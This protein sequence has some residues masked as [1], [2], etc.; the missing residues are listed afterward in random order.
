MLAA[1]IIVS[2]VF[3]IHMLY[4]LFCFL[5]KDNNYNQN[6]SFQGGRLVGTDNGGN[7]GQGRLLY[8]NMESMDTAVK[9]M[10]IPAAPVT[11]S[12]AGLCIRISHINT[13][14]LY[15]IYLENQVVIG[16]EGGS[17]FLQ[18]RDSLIS[19]KHC[20]I[21]RKG[22]QIFIQDLDSTNHT[23]LNGCVLESPMPIC[24]GDLIQIGRSTLQFQGVLGG[25]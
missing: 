19:N 20:M 4:L 21:Y 13:G 12:F 9:G 7:A 25:Y 6:V 1:T 17:A 22:E 8:N 14:Q 3:G 24:S 2:V 10:Q 5:S 11:S 18:L 16:R 15:D 23:Y